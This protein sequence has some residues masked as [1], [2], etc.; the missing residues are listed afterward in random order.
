MIN[1]GLFT[2][3]TN[4]WAT[5]DSLFKELDAE[6]HFDLDPCSTDDNAKCELHYTIDT[7]GLIQNWGGGGVCSV[8]PPMA[9][10]CPPGFASVPPN[11]KSRTRWWLCLFLPVLIHRTF[12]NTSGI[13][14]RKSVS[15]GADFISTGLNIRP[16]SLL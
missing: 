1:N 7:D 13:M 9:V 14:Q 4:E 16:R 3:N 10:N 15:S 5:P 8:I 2:S 6:F 12:M 11:R